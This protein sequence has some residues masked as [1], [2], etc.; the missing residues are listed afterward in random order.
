MKTPLN[1]P[2]I[3]QYIEKTHKEFM[4][5]YGQV[6]GKVQADHRL[7]TDIIYARLL[8]IMICL[9]ESEAI[10]DFQT[11]QDGYNKSIKLSKNGY[12]AYINVVTNGVQ[13]LLE[14]RVYSDNLLATDV[15]TS[16]KLFID[17]YSNDFDWEGFAKE[18]LEYIHSSLYER[19]TVTE[20]QIEGMLR[21]N[22]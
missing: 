13:I 21:D 11:S 3:Q 1:I 4:N 7:R 5:R 22:E 14:G 17:I 12:E 2:A 19:K 8:P 16:S 10:D 9:K 20:V 18:L 6:V 15:L